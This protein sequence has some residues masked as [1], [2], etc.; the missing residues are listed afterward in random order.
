MNMKKAGKLVIITLVILVL[1]ISSIILINAEEEI[2]DTIN[3]D[4][5]STIDEGCDDDYD[6]YADINMQCPTGSRFNTLQYNSS[7]QDLY[8][9]QKFYRDE[10]MNWF[11]SYGNGWIWTSF[12]CDT[13]SGDVDDDHPA[14]Y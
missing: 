7:Y 13:H 11:Y 10:E 5:D 3:N 1:I 9:E 4:Y 12:P 6:S 8:P 2:C 14:L